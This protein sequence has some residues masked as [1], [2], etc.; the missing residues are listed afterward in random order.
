[1]ADARIEAGSAAYNYAV[2]LLYSGCTRVEQL[3]LK[4]VQ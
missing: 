2:I 3:P 1:V 4:A